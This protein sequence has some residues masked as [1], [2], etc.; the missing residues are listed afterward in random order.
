MLMA[1]IAWCAN[2]SI[3]YTTS[4]TLQ[5][6]VKH[7]V[8]AVPI[9]GFAIGFIKI[10]VACLMLRFQPNRS[11]RVC[12]YVLITILA[13]VTL[14]SSIFAAFQC[15]PLAAI[16]DPTVVGAKCVGPNPVR[17][18]SNFF[19]AF[20]IATDI[21]LS[22]FP[23]TFLVKLRRPIIEKG[24]IYMLMGIGLTA[25]AAS[26]TKAVVIQQWVHDVD[27]TYVG[28]TIST[29]AAVEMLIGS[30]AACLPCLKSTIQRLLAS[31]GIDFNSEFSN[32]PAFF[33]SI[34]QDVI[35]GEEQSQMIQE[36]QDVTRKESAQTS[37]TLR[38]PADPDKGRAD[39]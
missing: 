7:G 1:G 19:G 31:M 17:G 2:S 38:S 5:Q 35:P 30:I 24:L 15:L 22:L 11:W 37:S 18:V 9:W 4:H 12:L 39:V 21:I 29:L 28:F 6:S 33:R 16:W 8:L 23:L 32:T 14:G 3:S 20:C 26:I 13:I 27:G 34:G 10:S 25:S 36:L